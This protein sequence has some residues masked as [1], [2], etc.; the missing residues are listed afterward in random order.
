MILTIITLLIG[1]L[2]GLLLAFGAW[3]IYPPAGLIVGGMLCLAWSW[4]VSK[5]IATSS[6]T[7][8]GD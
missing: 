7:S 4:W 3:M 1:V 8:G 5:S 6:T 2:G